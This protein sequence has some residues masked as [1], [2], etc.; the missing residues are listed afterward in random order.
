MPHIF[1]NKIDKK[2][3]TIVHHIQEWRVANCNESAGIYAYPYKWEGSIIC[4]NTKNKE[5]GLKFVEDNFDIVSELL[6][7]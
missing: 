5:E 6:H 2:L 3:Y 4:F 7:L 1:R